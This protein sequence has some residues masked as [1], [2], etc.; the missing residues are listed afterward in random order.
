MKKTLI[1]FVV[2]LSLFNSSCKKELP[3][4]LLHK[5]LSDQKYLSTIATNGS[6]TYWT[7]LLIQ[8]VTPAN[9]TYVASTGIVSWAGQN[10]AIAYVCS[11]QCSGY[12]NRV[13]TQ[14]YGY[15][16]SY[17]ASWMGVSYP[18]ATNY[19]N[20][21]ITQDHFTNIL[22][23]N[24][25]MQGDIIAMQYPPGSTATG[26]VMIVDSAPTL[27]TTSSPLVPGTSQYEVVVM[28]CSGSGHGSTDTR[29][30]S[31]GVFED[32]IGKGVFRL[33]VNST[34]NIVGYTW[35]TYS[36]STYYDQSQRH[37]AVGRLIP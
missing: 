28:D 18:K 9:N 37:L 36:N 34:G 5:S 12:L 13:L 17:Y 7:N 19:Y 2:F 25:I 21:I 24:Q 29:Y 3:D 20:E 15:T 6:P 14:T 4:A 33:Y 16:N 11:T 31:N 10:G 35:S 27:R 26:H 22:S 30:I 8:N 23:V 32:G 1:T